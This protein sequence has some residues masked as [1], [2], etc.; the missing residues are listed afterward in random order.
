MTPSRLPT[1]ANAAIARS[2]CSLG[3]LR[4]ELHA[5]ARLALRH[6][7]EREADHVDALVEQAL[8]ELAGEA[9]V[10]EHDGDD[11]A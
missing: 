3:V 5:D 4:G 1:V 11:R 9:R 6:D 8:R 10:A 7:R 2:T